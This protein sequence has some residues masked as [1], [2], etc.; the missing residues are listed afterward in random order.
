MFTMVAGKQLTFFLGNEKPRCQL[1]VAACANKEKA[2]KM[3]K[4]QGA[5]GY[6]VNSYKEVLKVKR[7]TFSMS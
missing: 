7:T 3:Y 5:H 6:N 2:F 4:I 1:A